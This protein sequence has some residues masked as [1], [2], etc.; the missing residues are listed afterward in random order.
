VLP[1][2]TDDSSDFKPFPNHSYPES[3]TIVNGRA[4]T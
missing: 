2:T 3:E 4:V 1:R